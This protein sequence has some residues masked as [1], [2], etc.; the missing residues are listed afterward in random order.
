[1]RG[2]QIIMG[3]AAVVAVAAG[4]A[5]ASARALPAGRAGAAGPPADTVPT[6]AFD[7]NAHGVIVGTS[8]P[9]AG[10][11]GEGFVL[12]H[13]VFTTLNVPGSAHHATAAKGINTAGDVVGDYLDTRGIM[14]GYLLHDG[15]YTTINVP[16]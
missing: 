10:A 2:M 12:A 13:G 9:G 8:F 6:G 1:M 14:H 7:I 4:A 15:A 3:T 5:G 11:S 16:R